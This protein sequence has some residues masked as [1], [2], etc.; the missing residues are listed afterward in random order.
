MVEFELMADVVG[1]YRREINTKGNIHKLAKI[2]ESDCQYFDDLMSKYSR[3]EHSQP[4]ESP[5]ELPNPQDLLADMTGLK[6][7]Q[8]E[9]AKRTV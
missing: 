5:V 1:R 6:K 3:F 4:T 2:S 9:Y 8:E 7:W